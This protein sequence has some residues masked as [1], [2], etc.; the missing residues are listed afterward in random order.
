MY[1][2]WTSDIV[3]KRPQRP[4]P[5]RRFHLPDSSKQT[6]KRFINHPIAQRR[7]MSQ[8]SKRKVRVQTR[9]IQ[10]DDRAF[11]GSDNK[12]KAV[13]SWDNLGALAEQYANNVGHR[14]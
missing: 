2:Q 8:S 3:V 11:L 12:L 1:A 9:S 5:R 10:C 6:R 13:V 14:R 4:T 7:R